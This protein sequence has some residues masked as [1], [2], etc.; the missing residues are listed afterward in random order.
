MKNQFD[1]SIQKYKL[2]TERALFFSPR[3][4]RFWLDE[5]TE[6][7]HQD[8]YD[9]SL[10][11]L[12]LEI[13]GQCNGR[14][15][16]CIVYGNHVEKKEIIDISS[17]WE[18]L[19]SL[20]WFKNIK[21]I[22]IIGGE[23]MLHFDD[24]IFILEHFNGTVSFSTNGTLITRERAKQLAHY[25][26]MVYISL[27][28]LTVNDNINR[29]YK[30]GSYMYPDIINGLELLEET[31]VKKGIFMVATQNTVNNISDILMKL[32]R[33]YKLSRIGYSMPHWTQNESDTVT[34]EQ[35]RDALLDLFD[36]RKEIN[37]DIMQLNW[38]L[39]PL[40]DG[41]VKEFSCSLHTQQIT[42]LPD[43]SVVRCSKIDSLNDKDVYT[44]DWLNENCPT[45]LADKSLEPCAS[46]IAL[47]SCGGGC[48][49][50]G[51]K[52]FQS[53]IDKR[54]C[55]V[56]RPLVSKAIQE[57]IRSFEN[58]YSNLPTGIICPS[59]IKRILYQ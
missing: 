11:S 3:Y 23:P 15:K 39:R 37:T 32:T 27:D 43:K 38:R 55:I 34:A 56:T 18:W 47:A 9:K 42:V 52:R 35:Y 57:I 5:I 28:G 48:P 46:C 59:V 6:I 33:Q 20:P 13:S 22:F 14:C 1:K 24:I 58:E 4:N 31:G 26:V 36:H 45:S 2:S 10:I 21:D 16:Y 30:D 54:E 50:D 29:I 8:Y 7:L 53:A 51:I 44:N 19:I 49:F 17:S 25:N 12:R 41:K 40:S